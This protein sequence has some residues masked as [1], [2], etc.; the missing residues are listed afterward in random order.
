MHD[1]LS[2]YEAPYNGADWDAMDR[3]LDALPKTNR[4]QW[5]FSLNTLLIAVGVASLISLGVFL[6]SGHSAAPGKPQAV[7]QP[8][9]DNNLPSKN[10]SVVTN[11]P[12]SQVQTVNMADVQE[13]SSPGLVTGNSS[14]PSPGNTDVVQNTSSARKTKTKKDSGLLFGDQIDPA[15][16]FIHRTQEDQK[17]ID[18]Y[19]NRGTPSVYFDKE[20]G[21]LKEIIINRDSAHVTGIKKDYAPADTTAKNTPRGAPVETE[22][23]GFDF[24]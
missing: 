18:Q 6:A 15:K 3:S 22:Q 17:L 23:H 7:A 14:N 21:Q 20:N 13:V 24:N 12:P 4:F 9:T 8:A 10:T 11:A 16:G 1:R 5:K 19:A 2:D